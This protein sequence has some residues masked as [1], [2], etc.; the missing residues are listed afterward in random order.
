M[1]PKQRLRAKIA[2]AKPPAQAVD[3]VTRD[4]QVQT[5]QAMHS[6]NGGMWQ[7]K[8]EIQQLHYLQNEMRNAI[9][10]LI[11]IVDRNCSATFGLA[12]ILMNIEKN[13]QPFKR[14][15]KCRKTR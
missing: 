10:S 6:V 2:P 3:Y 4:I 7:L 13:T 15:K 14:K 12:P 11:S 5:L 9:Y 8:N 1:T